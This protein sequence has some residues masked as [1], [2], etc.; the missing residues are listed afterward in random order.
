MGRYVKN[1]L[2]YLRG[3]CYLM[4]G[5]FTRNWRI[6]TGVR[7]FSSATLDFDHGSK[8]EIR[9]G[10]KI[11]ERSYLSVR[12]NGVLKICNNASIGMDCKIVVH[13]SV[14]IGEGTLLSPNV[15]IYDHDHL[16]DKESGVHRKSFNSKAI[17]IGKNCWIGAN[18]V[19]LKGAIIGD[20]CIVAAGSVICGTIPA[21]HIFVQKKENTLIEF[22]N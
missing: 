22:N 12:K 1:G 21:G 9:N 5:K 10:S 20:N 7:I 19:I 4:I 8:V 14:C 16:F 6:E 2:A 18:T 3:I 15:M 11:R 17:N 13:E